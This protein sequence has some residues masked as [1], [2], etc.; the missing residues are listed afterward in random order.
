MDDLKRCS[1]CD[2]NSLKSNFHKH[3]TSKFGIHAQCKSC[4]IPKQKEYD[5]ENKEKES[6]LSEKS[7]SNEGVL[8]EYV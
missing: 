8:S 1:N 4:V 3:S 2:N 6:F 7:S 5:S